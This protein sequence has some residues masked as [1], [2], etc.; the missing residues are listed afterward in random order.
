MIIKS[1]ELENIR[2]YEKARIDFPLGTMLFEGDV[3]SG[4]STILLAIE[5]ALFGL[6]NQKGASLLRVGAKEG[7]VTLKFEVDGQE[8]EV[9]RSLIRRGRGVQQGDDGYVKTSQGVKNLSPSE[10]KQE[11]LDILKFNEPPNP[12]AQSVIYRY[13]IYTPQEEMKAI[14]WARPDQRLQTLRKAFRIEDYRIATDNATNLAKAINKKINF[15][16][17]QA[18]DLEEKKKSIEEKENAVKENQKLL[19]K[20]RQEEKELKEKLE[21]VKKELSELQEDEK[22]LN[23][24]KTKVPLLT[25]QIEEKNKQIES[26]NSQIDELNQEIASELQPEIEKLS[27]IEKPTD[28]TVE[29][30]KHDL[31]ELKEKLKKLRELE[32][33]IDAKIKDYQSIEENGVCP[34][35]DRPADPQEFQTKINEKMEEKEKASQLVHKCEEEIK[36]QEELLEKINEYNKAQEKLKTLQTLLEKNRE[37]A[38]KAGKDVEELV[39]SRNILQKQLDAAIAECKKLEGVSER[40][41]GLNK[42]FDEIQKQLKHFVVKITQ[43]ETNIRNLEENINSLREEI[44]KK[45]EQKKL[46]E[47]LNEYHIWIKDYFIPTL[48]SIEKHVMVTINQEF[49]THFQKWFSLL[50][51]DPGKSARIDEDFTPIIEQDGYEQPVE[52][53]SGGEKT[54]VALAYRLALNSIVQKV[55]VGMKS[56][57]LILDEPTD[58]FSKEQLYKVREILNELQCP[59]IVIVSHERELE[60]FADH[61]FKVEKSQGVSNIEIAPET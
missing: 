14:L 21:N 40:I 45:E 61:I 57:M 1:L 23:A 47:K 33:T 46:S 42:T 6:G 18:S 12:K 43:A 2:S 38:E 22:K 30:L 54:S 50:V 55:S 26:L 53:L 28:K 58:G 17:G 13:A 39:K 48:D 32:T 36:Q 35:C 41:D 20:Y 19:E 31:N 59:Q 7:S 27:K 56:N 37:R 11:I 51:E 15:L 24:A 16:R 34:T 8:Y 49:N 10:L 4:K 29:A 60:S 25:K 5:F 44:R 3:G 52:F 9:H